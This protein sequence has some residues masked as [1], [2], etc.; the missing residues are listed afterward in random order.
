MKRL[1]TGYAFS[2]QE[3][4]QKFNIKN[5]TTHYSVLK[6]HYKT[7][8]KKEMAVKV[9]LH[10]IH[11]VL[12]DVIEKNVTFTLPTSYPAQIQMKTH[13]GSAFLNLVK[14]GKFSELDPFATGFKGYTLEFYYKL[15]SREK[16]KNIYVGNSLKN[17]ITEK[18]NSGKDF[19]VK[20]LATMTDYM[21]AVCEKFSHLT[22]EEIRK[23][24]IFGFRSYFY[25]NKSKADTMFRNDFFLMYTGT[26]FADYFKYHK[27]YR[28]KYGMKYRIKNKVKGEPFDGFYYFGLTDDLYRFYESQEGEPVKIFE[29]ISLFR[30]LDELKL[31]PEYKNHFKVKIENSKLYKIFFTHYET[32]D[33]IE[34]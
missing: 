13:D 28:F 1:K 24:L 17:K 5:I 8:E 9:F 33:V 14:H 2:C 4:F 34:L 22:R 19:Y 6:E 7:R 16:R 20:K 31:Y 18:A 26:L 15:K 3:M 27:Y 10:A 21:D 32:S 30:L 23:I 12:L 11:L 29:N 25:L